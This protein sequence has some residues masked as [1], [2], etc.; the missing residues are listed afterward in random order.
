MSGQAAAPTYRP[1]T[2]SVAHRICEH[3]VSHPMDRLDAAQIAVKFGLP[4]GKNVQSQLQLAIDAGY[5]L[6]DLAIAGR[7]A[8]FSAGPQLSAWATGPGLA[9]PRFGEAVA[10]PAPRPKA[11]AF[12]AKSAFDLDDALRQIRADAPHEVP[13]AEA[14]SAPA[15]PAA[16]PVAEAPPPAMPAPR[17]EAGARHGVFLYLRSSEISPEDL[18][19]LREAGLVPVE[20]DNFDDVKVIGIGAAGLPPGASVTQAV[21]RAAMSAIAIA[22]SAAGPKTRFGQRLAELLTKDSTPGT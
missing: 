19:A 6:H 5:V 4:S 20:V 3:F 14:P 22:D 9:I 12:V 7:G 11:L 15:A 10:T 2:G 18:Q 17:R 16:P 8:K 21:W 13:P 1:Q